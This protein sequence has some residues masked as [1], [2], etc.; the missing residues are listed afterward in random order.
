MSAYQRGFTDQTTEFFVKI[1]QCLSFSFTSKRFPFDW[2]NPIG[3][4][5]VI[6]IEYVICGYEFFIVAFT[7]ALGI[8]VFWFGIAV[9]KELK[10]IIHSM[11]NKTKANKSQLNELKVLFSEYI[12]THAAIKQLSA[13]QFFKNS[14]DQLESIES[15]RLIHDFADVFQPIFMALF[16]WSLLAISNALLIFQMEIVEFVLAFRT[17]E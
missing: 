10:R 9:I 7:L 16:T 5:I 12:H 1:M 13:F 4:L 3:Y 15:F 8:G 6:I 2:T 14:K 17:E 11:N